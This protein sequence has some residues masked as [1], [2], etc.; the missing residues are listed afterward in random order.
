ME[1]EQCPSG[2][3][4]CRHC[5]LLS[6]QRLGWG[7]FAG[8]AKPSF[9][10]V[11]FSGSSLIHHELLRTDLACIWRELH[12]PP[13]HRCLC[14]TCTPTHAQTEEPQGWGSAVP[15]PHCKVLGPPGIS[16]NYTVRLSR[17]GARL[18]ISHELLGDPVLPV[19]GPHFENY[20]SDFPGFWYVH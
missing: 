5:N 16:L 9:F 1:Y 19:H 18:C 6:A 10:P 17:S 4:S 7:M 3:L 8:S 11:T 20:C 14:L 12:G 13:L 2:C 15:L